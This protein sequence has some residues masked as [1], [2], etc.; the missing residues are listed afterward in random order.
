LTDVE[1]ASRRLSWRGA[2]ARLRLPSRLSIEPSDLTAEEEAAFQRTAQ[3]LTAV[4]GPAVI[5]IV[6]G[7]ILVWWPLDPIVFAARPELIPLFAEWRAVTA[8]SLVGT[9][10]VARR[11]GLAARHPRMFASLTMVGGFAITA[12]FMGQMGSVEDRWFTYLLP[13][14]LFTTILLLPLLARLA[15]NFGLLLA[16]WLAFVAAQPEALTYPP[17]F[18]ALSTFVFTSLFGS[19]VGHVTYLAQR[20]NVTAA[21]RLRLSESEVR[22]LAATLEGRVAARTVELRKAQHDAERVRAQERA[23]MVRELHDALGQELTALRYGVKLLQTQAGDAVAPNAFDPVE[24][25]LQRV[26]GTVRRLLGGLGAAPQSTEQ[27]VGSLRSLLAEAGSAAGLD[28]TLKVDT[29]A[30]GALSESLRLA[31]LRVVQE[32]TTNVMRHAHGTALEVTVRREEGW[33]AIAVADDGVGMAPGRSPDSLGVAGIEQ[34]AAELGG[35]ATWRARPAGGT[36]LEVR[37]PWTK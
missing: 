20:A 30:L 25:L 16:T 15:L 33:V 36:I 10:L 19:F 22:D 7:F 8:L 12:W 3:E 13:A 1:Q 35:T 11:A 17:N 31:V 6:T 21:R 27:L 29:P 14:P 9:L 32:G 28:V 2:L 4:N 37:L 24:D 18:T 5:L 26:S 34:R 23:W